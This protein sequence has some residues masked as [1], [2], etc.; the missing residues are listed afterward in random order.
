MLVC[1]SVMIHNLVRADSL[2]RALTL[3]SQQGY[4]R[5]S[6][7]TSSSFGRLWVTSPI[8][9]DLFKMDTITHS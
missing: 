3:I 5:L 6:P 4:V 2:G 9:Y 8:L 1:T 7:A